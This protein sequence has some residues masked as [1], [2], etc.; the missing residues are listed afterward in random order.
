M[1]IG[2]LFLE[3][4]KEVRKDRCGCLSAIRS[5]WRNLDF[6]RYDPCGGPRPRGS[7]AKLI[8]EKLVLEGMGEASTIPRGAEPSATSESLGKGFLSR[9]SFSFVA[10]EVSTNRWSDNDHL[11]KLTERKIDVP[12]TFCHSRHSPT[13]TSGDAERS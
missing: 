8:L 4:S 3:N 6:A 12:F 2:S 10:G 7:N 9:E 13:I 5:I 1:R 11:M